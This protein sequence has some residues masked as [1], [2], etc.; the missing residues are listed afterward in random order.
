MA[1]IPKKSTRI[2]MMIAD[3]SDFFMSLFYEKEL[4]KSLC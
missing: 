1:K 2:M 4:M 3:F